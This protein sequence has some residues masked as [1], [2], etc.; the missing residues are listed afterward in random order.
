MEIRYTTHLEEEAFDLLA[1]DSSSEKPSSGE[2]DPR[3]DLSSALYL[4][5]G[6]AG[7]DRRVGFTSSASTG[8]AGGS[9][10]VYHVRE[11]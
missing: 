5:P 8:L 7:R 10:A 3:P 4:A 1:L 11:K 2:S 6:G 9:E